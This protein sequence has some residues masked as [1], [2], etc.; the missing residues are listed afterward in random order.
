[1]QKKIL[2]GLILVLSIAVLIAAFRG[3]PGS[4]SMGGLSSG[5]RGQIGVIFIEGTITGDTGGSSFFGTTAGSQTIVS[6]LK[7]ARE[8]VG[9][10][11]VL[12]RINSPGGS[13]VASQEIGEEVQ[14]LREAGKPVVTSMGDLAASGGYWIAASTNRIVANPATMTGSIGVIMQIQN[15]EELYRKLGIGFNTIKSGPLKDI[16]SDSRA[17]TQEERNI[18]QSM[19]DD[20]YDQFV[21]V[22][23]EGRGMPREKVIEL[24]DGRVYTGRQAIKLGLVDDLGDFQQ[25]V[26]ITAE[27]AGIKGEPELKYYGRPS[28][29]SIFFNTFKGMSNN[30]DPLPRAGSYGDTILNSWPVF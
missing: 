22:V 27:I 6:E 5:S 16:G 25:A 11:A 17:L 13:A 30:S 23:A 15:L 12:I 8:D 26:D 19:V 18:L 14:R 2:A 20:I 10:K 7:Q 3:R 21:D 24:A 1:M 4:L 29:F 9:T 28:P